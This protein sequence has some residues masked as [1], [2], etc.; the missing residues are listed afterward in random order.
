MS[1]ELEDKI[2]ELEFKLYDIQSSNE[3]IQ[4]DINIILEKMKEENDRASKH[5]D[6][7]YDLGQWNIYQ[8]EEIKK[9][10]NKL[11]I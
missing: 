6:C 7:P 4:I 8:V 1:E 10:I 11:I 2:T 9:L 5:D 3:E